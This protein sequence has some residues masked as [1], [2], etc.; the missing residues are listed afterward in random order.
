MINFP[1]GYHTVNGMQ[2]I[3]WKGLLFRKV[4]A[5]EFYCWSGVMGPR[6]APTSSWSDNW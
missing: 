6:S 5:A 4:P 3:H 1:A 2:T